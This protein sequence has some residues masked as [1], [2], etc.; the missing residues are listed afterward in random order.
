MPYFVYL[1]ASKPNGTLYCGVTNDLIRRTFEH[2]EG[3]AKG[4]TRRYDVKHLVWY[5]PHDDVRE[6][7]HRETRIKKWNRAW[8]IELIER[9][10]PGWCD[11]YET[12]Q[13]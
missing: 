1:L 4:F 3:Q 13:L 12:L 2:R 7:I 10:N 5:E 11:L 8:K 6:A 9:M